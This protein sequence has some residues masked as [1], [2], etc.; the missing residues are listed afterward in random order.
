MH[1]PTSTR[2]PSLGRLLLM[3][4]EAQQLHVLPIE[5]RATVPQLNDMVPDQPI[6]RTAPLAPRPALVL[7]IAHQRSPFRRMVETVRHLWQGGNTRREP[8][9]ARLD[10]RQPAHDPVLM[11]PKST[12]RQPVIVTAAL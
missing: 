4:R 5:R 11:F 7:D 8:A 3:M 9:Q 2:R 1:F 10:I 6:G 12:A